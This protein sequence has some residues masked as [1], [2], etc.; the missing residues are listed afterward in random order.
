M[1]ISIVI[2][3]ALGF[4]AVIIS[5]V[6]YFFYVKSILEKAATGAIDSAEIDGKKGV[7]KLDIATEQVFALVPTFLKI[8][9]TRDIVK[10]MVQDAFDKIE[11]YAKKQILK[12][13]DKQIK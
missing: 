2:N 10:N 11:A 1:E 6:S 5:F 7:E 12:K 13:K 8:V 4:A 3:V 9:I